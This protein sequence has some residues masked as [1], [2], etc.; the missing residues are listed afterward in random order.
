MRRGPWNHNVQYHD[1]VLHAVPP[2]C[3]HALDVGCGQ[4]ELAQRLA[5][6]CGQVT[7]IDCAPFDGATAAPG[8]T[9]LAADFMRHPFPA[10]SFDL[11]AAVAVL[12]HLPLRPALQRFAELLRPGGVLAVIGLYRLQ[13]PV[14]IAIGCCALP[15]SWAIRRCIGEA[16]VGAPIQ[17]P[18]ET[19]REIR[20]AADD[21]LPGAQFR[22]HF[23]FRYSLL[24]KKR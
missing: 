19:L 13:T 20:E 15:I 21:E 12:H 24:W 23:F 11:I 22:R 3:G 14:D 18:K 1:I 17:D 6:V 16:K 5:T 8:V 9:F 2:Q 10:A 4:G 7:A